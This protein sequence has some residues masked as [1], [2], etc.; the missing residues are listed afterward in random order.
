MEERPAGAGRPVPRLAASLLAALLA[1]GCASMRAAE[2]RDEYL[3]KAL[4]AYEYPKSCLEL[5]PSVVRLL[6]GKGYSLV[7]GDRTVAGQPPQG[8][9]SSTMSAGYETRGTGGGDL[10]VGTDW[11]RSW[12]RY[13]ANGTL[14]GPASC[15]VSFTRIW[16]DSVDMA[17]ENSADS[18]Q[19]ELDLLKSVDPAAAARIEAQAPKG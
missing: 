4:G 18:P 3:A 19:M 5:W 14:T 17:G 9:F 15:Q 12:T 11:N 10:T 16:K 8:G 13:V 6:A 7:G 2:A 1:S